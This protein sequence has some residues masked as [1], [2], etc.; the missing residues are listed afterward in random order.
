M[1]TAAIETDAIVIGAGPV[2]LFAVFELG[3]VRL[4]CHVVDA[5]EAVGGQ[6]VALYPT[7]PIYDIPGYP[8]ICG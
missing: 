3:M 6:L 4:R 1:S 2:G 7:K 5:L 8:K